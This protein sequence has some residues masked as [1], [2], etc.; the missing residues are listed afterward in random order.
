[1][2][3]IKQNRETQSKNTITNID[4]IEKT[5]SVLKDSCNYSDECLSTNG[6]RITDI[7][8]N[9]KYILVFGINPAGDENDAQAE[10]N[11]TYLYSLD[12]T[13]I[14]NRT[15]NKYYKPI[16]ALLSDATDAT[17]KWDW[18][19]LSECDINKMIE[20]DSALHKFKNQILSYYSRY[21]DET[22]SICIGE[23]FYYH[24]TNQAK[25]LEFVKTE[26]V[27]Y[28][29]YY[30]SML[31]MHI[32]AITEKGHEIKAILIPNATASRNLYDEIR[33][34]GSEIEKDKYPSYVNYKFENKEYRIFFSS[35]LSGQRAID[36]FSRD[37]LCSDLKKYLSE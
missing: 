29:N 20:K 21:K 18:C 15:Y 25:F 27:N 31:E 6:F 3:T 22:Y 28:K 34:K 7:G 35:M 32:K 19:N 14:K 30:S 13:N 12:E 36:V 8:K 4:F 1:M 24:E 37:R 33:N 11:A 2:N 26:D 10:V 9:K 17:V 23:F 5:K 16:F